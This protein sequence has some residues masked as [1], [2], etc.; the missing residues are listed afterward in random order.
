ME[1]EHVAL[2]RDGRP[3]DDPLDVLRGQPAQVAVDAAVREPHV[4]KGRSRE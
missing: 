3:R 1:Q 2:A 4:A